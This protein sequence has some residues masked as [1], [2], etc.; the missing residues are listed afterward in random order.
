MHL[1]CRNIQMSATD[2]QLMIECSYFS[3]GST[4]NYISTASESRETESRP[5]ASSHGYWIHQLDTRKNSTCKFYLRLAY[6][7]Q[8][9]K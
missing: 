5:E 1:Y 2:K 8:K 9:I 7:A 3:V 6:V 4:C